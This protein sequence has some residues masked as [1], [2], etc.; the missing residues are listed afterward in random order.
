MNRTVDIRGKNMKT[1]FA[2]FLLIHGLSLSAW[3]AYDPKAID[4]LTGDVSASGPG[5]VPATIQPNAVT[6]AKLAQ[7]PADTIKC[8]NTGSLADSIDCTITQFLGFLGIL[9]IANGGTNSGTALV[10]GQ[11]MM[12][13]AGKIVEDLNVYSNAGAGVSIGAPM[14]NAELGATSFGIYYASTTLSGYEYPSTEYYLLQ[15]AS[16]QT[17]SYVAY[18]TEMALDPPSSSTAMNGFYY[19]IYTDMAAQAGVYGGPVIANLD[20]VHFDNTSSGV[21]SLGQEVTVINDG[22]GEVHNSWGVSI[23]T[24]QAT[25]TGPNAHRGALLMLGDHTFL[26]AHDGCTTSGSTVSNECDA[27]YVRAG[28]MNATG[29]GASNWVINSQDTDPSQFMGS[30]SAV[31]LSTTTLQV[32][33]GA[34]TGDVLTSDSAGHATWQAPS[35]GAVSS[36]SNS[37]G[38]L[39][40]SPT[41]GAVVASLNLGSAN[42]WTA[43]QSFAGIDATSVTDSGL[44]PS[45]ALIAGAGGLLE[46]SV[47]TATELSYSSG[48]TSNIQNQFTSQQSQ[49]NTVTTTANNA[50]NKALSNLAAT[51]VNSTIQPATNN[52]IDL[53]NSTHE[54]AHVYAGEILSGSSS[55]YILLTSSVG[56]LYDASAIISLGWSNRLEYDTSGNPSLDWANRDLIDP[57][58]TN[59]EDWGNRFLIDA[60]NVDS[61]DWSNR[62]LLDPSDVTSVDWANRFLVDASAVT[63]LDWGN[64]LLEDDSDSPSVDWADR[65]LV[66][67]AGNDTVDWQNEFLYDDT[68]TESVDWGSRLLL[69]STG[70]QELAWSTTGVQVDTDLLLSNAHITTQQASP[71]TTTH[72]NAGVG[73]V[74]TLNASNN[75]SDVKGQIN[76]TTGTLPL[77][78]AYCQVNFVNPYT[79]YA[80]TCVISFASNNGA[81][82]MYVTSTTSS[83]TLNFQ[84]PG[85]ATTNYLINYMCME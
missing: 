22:T 35:A 70:S 16:T 50:A 57:S 4:G 47:T 40:I 67:N 52:S 68:F 28:S 71:T 31:G 5:V 82:V 64:R 58:G 13:S 61:E 15:P 36:V 43:T 29:T 74:C 30:I 78:G 26:G 1:I 84:T 6:N 49:I 55:P 73:A 20:Y 3:G 9:P 25:G 53:G 33:T 80:P 23:D 17:G 79:S 8:N 69:D 56:R 60:S 76:L 65:F 45:T 59:S 38:T 39:T 32:T 44:T 54:W 48:V 83:M 10:N 42:T 12:S 41:T 37:D 63:A 2:A 11:V 66:D 27:I 24:V 46:S 85:P 75:P 34:T 18:V 81:M 62:L 14:S 72:T 21:L 51:G 77:G 19:G 7:A